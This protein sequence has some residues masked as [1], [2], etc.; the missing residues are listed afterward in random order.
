MKIYFSGSI[1]G[2]REKVEAYSKIVKKLQE[3]G[4]VLTAHVADKNLGNSGEQDLSKEEIYSRDMKW[5]EEADIVV[6]E[7]T[8]ASLGVGYELAV[9]EKFGKRTICFFDK[10]SGKTLSAMIEGDKFYDV[11]YYSNVEEVLNYIDNNI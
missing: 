7:T 3:Y 9:A 8:V 10:T 5:L 4:D 1:R 11:V 6:A 2:G